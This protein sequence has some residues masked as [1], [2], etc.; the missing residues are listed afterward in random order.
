MPDPL[1]TGATESDAWWLGQDSDRLLNLTGWIGEHPATGAD[2]AN[3]LLHPLGG[4]V[5]GKMRNLAGA[6]G[7]GRADVGAMTEVPPDTTWATL[8]DAPEG[9]S[10]WLHYGDTAWLH[11]PVTAEW[12]TAATGQRMVLLIVGMDGLHVRGMPDVERYLRRPQR[13]YTGLIRLA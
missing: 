3:L 1:G 11:R 13:L 10:V 7:L 12:E 4:G 8:G 9:R 2:V 5:A 6:L